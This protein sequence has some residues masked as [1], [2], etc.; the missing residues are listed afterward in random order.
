MAP[1]DYAAL[2]K[3]RERAKS[4][5]FSLHWRASPVEVSRFG[6]VVAKR[7]AR[8]AI[9]RNLIKRQARALFAL[10]VGGSAGQS[11][12]STSGEAPRDV[13]LRLTRNPTALA[14]AQQYAEL[15]GLFAALAAPRGG[16]R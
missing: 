1:D 9:R 11:A 13:V 6:M 10:A 16:S 15:Q 12:Q 14:R 8:T 5:H 3:S 2:F 4:E 7:L